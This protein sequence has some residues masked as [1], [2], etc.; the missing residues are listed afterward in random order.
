MSRKWMLHVQDYGKTVRVLLLIRCSTVVP[1]CVCL[2]WCYVIVV[3]TADVF[4]VHYHECRC[5]VGE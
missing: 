5:Q 3:V 1:R 4:Y 2:V